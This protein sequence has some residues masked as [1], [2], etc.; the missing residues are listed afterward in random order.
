MLVFPAGFLLRFWG[1]C[2]RNWV[3]SP[4]LIGFT[5]LYT[6]TFPHQSDLKCWNRTSTASNNRQQSATLSSKLHQFYQAKSCVVVYILGSANGKTK[7]R[8]PKNPRTLSSHWTWIK[9]FWVQKETADQLC[10]KLSDFR[11]FS[12]DSHWLK[13]NRCLKIST[14][15]SSIFFI[16]W[17]GS[18]VF[19]RHDARFWSQQ[20]AAPGEPWMLRFQSRGQISGSQAGP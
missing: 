9:G 18:R 15:Q 4:N 3:R 17:L 14:T 8:Q 16:D 5:W 20:K 6:W 10:F 19:R 13:K 1:N 2:W 7:K 11:W 12:D